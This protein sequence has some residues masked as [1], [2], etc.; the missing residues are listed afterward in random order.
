MGSEI[1]IRDSLYPDDAEKALLLEFVK[2][3]GPYYNTM[4]GF[5]NMRTEWWTMLQNITAGD[6]VTEAANTAVE[7]SNAGMAG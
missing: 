5:A 1:G 4:D 2:M 6:D 7:N 3:Y